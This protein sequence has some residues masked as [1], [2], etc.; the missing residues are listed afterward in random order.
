MKTCRLTSCL[1]I[2][3]CILAITT[4]NAWSQSGRK[5]TIKGIVTSSETGEPLPYVSVFL[6]NT[7]V[8]TI[9]DS[10]GKYEI[11]TSATSYKIQ[12]S[13][14]GY[15]KVSRIITPGR[16][17]EIN[18]T[19]QPSSVTLGEVVVK[20]P[21]RSYSNKNN[22]AVE[23]IEK[24]IRNKDLN[25]KEGLDYFSYD[26][27]EKIVFSLS[28]IPEKFRQMRIFS[29]FSFIFGEPGYAGNNDRDTI[30]FFITEKVSD[31]Y[32]RKNP[33]SEKEIIR[34]EK[35]INFDE[36]IDYKGVTSNLNYMYQNIDIYENNIFFLTNKFLSPIAPEAPVFYRF[37]INDTLDIGEVTC[38]KLFFEPRNPADFLFHGFL[39]I[40]ADSAYAVKKIDMS[41]N[42]GINIDWV[43]DVRIVQEFDKTNDSAWLLARDEIAIDFG[44][45]E[46]L[47]GLFGQRTV[48][49]NNYSVNEPLADSLFDG[50]ATVTAPDAGGKNLQYWESKRIPPLKRKE[51]FIYVM[52]DSVK[53]VPAF[54]RKMDIVMLLTTEFLNLGKFE[55]GP[56]GN[57][58]SFNP[59]EGDRIRFGGRTTPEFSR[60]L[61]LEPYLAYGF[62]DR[63]VKYN[64]KTTYSLTGTSVYQFPVRSVSLNWKYD[65]KFPGQELQYATGDNIFLSLKR[66]RADKLL[67]DKTFRVEYINEF[68]N[69]FSWTLGYDFTRESAAG[70]LHFYDGNDLQPADRIRNINISEA[71]LRLRYA[72]REE[73]Y[74]GKIYRDPVPSVYPVIRLQLSAGSKQLNGDYDYQRLLFGI[75]R[76]FYLSIIG[77]TDVSAEAGRIFGRV[78]YPLLFIHNANQTYSYQRYSY[79]MMNFL[80]FVSDRYVALNIDHSF[81]GFFLNKVPLIKKLKFRE[82]ITF[83]A[84]YGGLGRTNDP[85][86][87][88]DLFRFPT[89]EDGTPLTYT[90]G[91][92]PYIEGSIGV[93]NV[94]HIFRIDLIKRFSYLDNPDVSEYGLRIQFRFDI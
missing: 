78:S 24:V 2:F 57:F 10:Q 63:Q 29:K 18:I 56:V 26:K 64:L 34:A 84:L 75:S 38:I 28:N 70:I 43:K 55:T 60:W 36:Y 91:K 74:Q 72:P 73:F 41:F 11:I 52:V 15:E 67:Y 7:S 61:Y 82:V 33:R 93:S 12:F 94:L 9:T 77:Y 53:K 13:F 45:T 8:G 42:K 71:F 23:L 69:H 44:I 85:D 1:I 65:T 37:F 31:F 22:P 5:T 3:P 50:P 21:K 25:R 20:P 4:A 80:E 51:N 88:R 19:M 62:T 49:Y 40:T 76:R 46:N 16:I 6:E 30:P 17:Q 87:H 92:K 48:S 39:F 66:G 81:N 86:L 90:L 83:K 79:N 89:R 54:K 47:P 68:E 32:S 27:Y 59:V 14:L 58:Y 35:T